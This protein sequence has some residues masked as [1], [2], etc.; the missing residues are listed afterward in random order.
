MKKGESTHHISYNP[1]FKI[2]VSRG[3]HLVLTGFQKM[4]PTKEN[5]KQIEDFI[6]AVQFILWQKKS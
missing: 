4:K 3:A 2:K 1:E 5:I 6:K